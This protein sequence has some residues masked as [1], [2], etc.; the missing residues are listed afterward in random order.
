MPILRT[1][2]RAAAALAKESAMSF[3]IAVRRLALAGFA[4]AFAA[5]LSLAPAEAAEKT[6]QSEAKWIAYDA[7]TKT[8]KVKIDKP[9]T[10]PNKDKLKRNEEVTFRVVPEGSVLTRTSVAIN[11]VKGEL[12]DIPADK[13]VN[14]YWLPDPE[15]ASGF[16][17]RKIDVVLSDEEL[18][19]RAAETSKTN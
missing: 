7:A 18:D 2:H 1:P 6:T 19:K 11:G 10:G 4:G 13:R 3:Q 16:F 5:A 14:V 8:V 9:G 15:N 17:A 12:T